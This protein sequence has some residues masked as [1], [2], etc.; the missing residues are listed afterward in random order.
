L[1]DY[2]LDGVIGDAVNV[3]PISSEEARALGP[4]LVL[5][6]RLGRFVAQIAGGPIEDVSIRYFGDAAELATGVV[7]DHLLCGLLQPVLADRVNRVSARRLAQERGIPFSETRSTQR[8]DYSGLISVRLRA[9]GREERV[10]GTVLHRERTRLVA[11]DGIDIESPLRG[12]MLF[13]RNR[14]VPGVIGRIGSI[15]G[16]SGINIGNFAL[17]R[18][19]GTDE[20]VAL[21]AVDSPVSRPVLAHLAAVEAITLVRPLFFP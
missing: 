17:G 20:A 15:L 8:H 3:P 4:Y 7:T 5:A 11:V 6:E 21:V 12:H 19:S 14:D 16:E 9:G 18:R 13:L 1:R 2:L 10:E